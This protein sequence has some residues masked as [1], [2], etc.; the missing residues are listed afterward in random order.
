MIKRRNNL[1]TSRLLHRRVISVQT[2]LSARAPRVALPVGSG[3]MNVVPHR[4]SPPDSDQLTPD[5][6]P[7]LPRHCGD[8]SDKLRRARSKISTSGKKIQ[9]KSAMVRSRMVTYKKCYARVWSRVL[10]LDIA[11]RSA[12]LVMGH[13]SRCSPMR[14]SAT[15]DGR[16]TRTCS[17]HNGRAAIC[18]FGTAQLRPCVV[19]PATLSSSDSR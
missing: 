13:G 6:S 18:L 15:H 3:G 14:P 19:L 10:D 2:R 11:R 1:P 17:R 9:T 7:T 4:I 5:A 16:S 8:V 12:L